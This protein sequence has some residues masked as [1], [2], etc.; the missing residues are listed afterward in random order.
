MTSPPKWPVLRQL[1]RYQSHLT[2]P[3][4]PYKALEVFDPTSKDVIICQECLLSFPNLSTGSNSTIVAVIVTI[5]QYQNVEPSN[6]MMIYANLTVL[7]YF[8]YDKCVVVFHRLINMW[9]L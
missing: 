2:T 1:D 4:P 6:I 7:C 9:S 5:R 8:L 3:G